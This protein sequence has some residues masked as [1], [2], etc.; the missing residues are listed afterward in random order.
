MYNNSTTTADCTRS[1][2][3]CVVVEGKIF[4][5]MVFFVF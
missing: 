4:V 5:V 3:R 1:A 2:Y